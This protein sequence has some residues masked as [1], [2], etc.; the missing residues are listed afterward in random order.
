MYK[1]NKYS[2]K[3]SNNHHICNNINKRNNK[4]SKRFNKRYN[5]KHSNKS[6]KRYNKYKFSNKSRRSNYKINYY[7][8]GTNNDYYCRPINN[9]EKTNI[10]L[11]KSILNCKCPPLF[12]NLSKFNYIRCDCNHMQNMSNTSGDASCL[13]LHKLLPPSIISN[14]LIQ[15]LINIINYDM[16]YIFRYSNI[17]CINPNYIINLYNIF[18]QSK[19]SESYTFNVKING[20]PISIFNNLIFRLLSTLMIIDESHIYKNSYHHIMVVQAINISPSSPFRTVNN[21]SVKY[22]DIFNYFNFYGI[23]NNITK[24]NDIIYLIIFLSHLNPLITFFIKILHLKILSNYNKYIYLTFPGVGIYLSNYLV[25]FKNYINLFNNLN[26]NKYIFYYIIFKLTI[27]ELIDL[28]VQYLNMFKIIH[29]PHNEYIELKNI[30]QFESDLNTI[31][32][33]QKTLI[34]VLH[35]KNFNIF[36]IDSSPSDD[37]IN[38][39]WNDFRIKFIHTDIISTINENKNQSVNNNYYIYMGAGNANKIGGGLHLPERLLRS[40]EF[41]SKIPKGAQE[42]NLLKGYLALKS[43]TDEL[44]PPINKAHIASL[45]NAH[46]YA[47]NRIIDIFNRLLSKYTYKRVEYIN[48]IYS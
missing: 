33:T 5:R 18:K 39:F 26:I 8:G 36:F 6:S 27:D 28:Q 19:F 47:L 10:P 14:Q 30:L 16:P 15:H 37:I 21:L 32:N 2:N 48:R 42:E 20:D 12:D 17:E 13:K 25:E 23:V 41:N 40:N 4:F 24:Q 46:N 45:M 9:S 31:I 1:F 7:G 29:T 11:S 35:S 3:R 43:F 38:Q 22:R 34:E 44:T